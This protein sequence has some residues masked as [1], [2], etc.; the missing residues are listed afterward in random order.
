[1][2]QDTARFKVRPAFFHDER[3]WWRVRTPPGPLR[4]ATST[5]ARMGEASPASPMP[6]GSAENA[7]V[8]DLWEWDGAN[9]TERTS[10][11]PS[12]RAWMTFAY[13][14]RRGRTVLFGGY[15]GTL[16]AADAWEWDG[17]AWAAKSRPGP[18]YDNYSLA[19]AA[20]AW[21]SG[22]GKVVL[23]GG[24]GE[25]GSSADT[26]E[27][28]GTL[29]EQLTPASHPNPKRGHV[30][31]YDS[32]RAR[33]VLFGGEL[34]QDETW[35]WDGTTWV[36]AATTGPSARTKAAM[37]Y[38]SRRGVAVLFGGVG[39]NGFELADTWEW[40]GAGWTERVWRALP[41]GSGAW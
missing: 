21:D 25:A 14:T 38:D 3:D 23:F 17:N 9:W 40:D 6:G 15:D 8:A 28:E 32:R 29:W 41:R 35:T 37:A 19:G 31:A 4:T 34:Y 24:D 7:G 33:T 12:A 27:L 10:P 16:V 20:M 1:M 2:L 13:D 30:M 18:V 11:G 39:S 5:I 36:L 26:W 22:R